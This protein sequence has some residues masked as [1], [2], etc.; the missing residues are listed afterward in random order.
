[1]KKLFL[2]FFFVT[3]SAFCTTD[4]NGFCSVPVA[5]LLGGPIHDFFTI[6]STKKAYKKLPYAEK[7]NNFSSPRIAQLIFNQPVIIKEQRAEEIKVE[8]PYLR[9]ASTNGSHF[10]YWTLASN[11]TRLTNQNKIF[12]PLHT[13]KWFT[14]KQAVTLKGNTY[15]AGTK[16]VCAK[17]QK[18]T[19]TVYVYNSN[20]HK[21]EKIRIK[22]NLGITPP[23]HFEDK[24][25]L[26]VSLCKEWANPKN[27]FIP[28][29]FGGL[30]IDHPLQD[31]TY[32]TKKASF[33]KPKP[34]IFYTRPHE[35]TIKTGIDCARMVL[36]AA[37]MS[38]LPLYAINTKEL[39]KTLRPL[40]KDEPVE[41]GDIIIWK[42]HAAIIS[43]AQ[44]GLMIEARSYDSGYG[45]IHEIPYYK[46]LQG[47][48][49]TQKLMEAHFN[50]LPLTRL[51]KDGSKSHLIYDL[52]ILKLSTL[53]KA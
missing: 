38:G 36:K 29:V 44:N 52:E 26:F 33:T 2:M 23:E 51:N 18:Y 39:R 46:Q 27:G 49:T 35:P 40:K 20:T 3:L 4:Y 34:S 17:K 28:Y 8:I 5:D 47:I 53:N 30:S 13:E 9:Y 16:F 43:D 45:K 7:S 6:K 41:D 32:T 22:K 25:Q 50:K 10:T 24:K 48:T 14:L 1:M 15:S 37:E 11:I 21:P 19:I 12:T 42:G 31:D